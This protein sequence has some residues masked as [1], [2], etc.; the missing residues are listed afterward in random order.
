MKISTLMKRDL[1][2][3]IKRNNDGIKQKTPS[4]SEKKDEVSEKIKAR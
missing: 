2:Q 4:P 3:I 1:K